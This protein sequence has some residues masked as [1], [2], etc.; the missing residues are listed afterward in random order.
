MKRTFTLLII[1]L[2]AINIFAQRATVQD[3]N[4]QS[5]VFKRI[6]Q[7]A[8][9]N[10]PVKKFAI[11]KLLSLYSLQSTLPTAKV[12]K[13]K[14]D[15][16]IFVGDFD[17]GDIIDGKG[18]TQTVLLS[19][20]N[21]LSNGRTSEEYFSLMD[22]LGVWNELLKLE[23]NYQNE[24]IPAEAIVSFNM[25]G[26]WFEVAKADFVYDNPDY[27]LEMDVSVF[28]QDNFQMEEVLKVYF[29]MDEGIVNEILVS[30][31]DA[32]TGDWTDVAK[33]TFTYMGKG[34]LSEVEVL[35]NNNLKEDLA[36]LLKLDF[37]YEDNKVNEIYD[38]IWIDSLN[39]YLPVSKQVYAYDDMDNV[40]EI[41]T[42]AHV[43]EGK[44]WVEVAKQ[45]YT[46]NND[47]AYGDM[48]LPFDFGMNT[49]ATGDTRLFNHML[50]KVEDYMYDEEDSMMVK[51]ATMDF[52]YST[53]NFNSVNELQGEFAVSIYPNPATDF[54]TFKFTSNDIYI[55]KM[56]DLTGKL[57]LTTRIRN[58][59]KISIEN[60]K[61]GIYFYQLERGSVHIS[62]KLIKQ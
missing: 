35:V 45:V 26:I 52:Y 57:V 46:Y 44:P 12:E 59:D 28:N 39:M 19:T 48:V 37:S 23:I 13:Q 16:L 9:P 55:L 38:L 14:M 30:G 33:I 56:Y 22:S 36:K 21:Y 31:V 10:D 8:V 34:N 51:N 18:E 42:K 7:K 4:V 24:I 15:S 53:G 60:L 40:S 3:M 2:F 11:E 27:S 5:R 62:G 61:E 43:M 49:N 17:L 58:D 47:Y 41:S 25:N 1:T 6:A 50:T 29:T 20:F 54:V 32:E